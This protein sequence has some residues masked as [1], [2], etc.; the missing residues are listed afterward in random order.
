MRARR[1]RHRG[2]PVERDAVAVVEDAEYFAAPHL[3]GHEVALLRLDDEAEDAAAALV[4][5]PYTPG[6]PLD[7]L[8]ARDR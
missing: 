4:V 2:T 1:S 7:M 3:D 8:R 5:D 6:D